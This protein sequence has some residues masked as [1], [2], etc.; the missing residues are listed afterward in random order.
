MVTVRLGASA[1]VGQFTEPPEALPELKSSVYRRYKCEKEAAAPA[2]EAAMDNGQQASMCQF[3][4]LHT[5]QCE[6]K[7]RH[8][9]TFDSQCTL[10]MAAAD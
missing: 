3:G 8:N 1:R 5:V 6:G 9:D 4:C 2:A 7:A 10:T